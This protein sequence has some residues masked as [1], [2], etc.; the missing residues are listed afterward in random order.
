[1]FLLMCVFWSRARVRSERP[2]GGFW[3]WGTAVGAGPGSVKVTMGVFA[4]HPVEQ[5]QAPA[6][7]DQSLLARRTHGRAVNREV[8][9]VRCAS[10]CVKKAAGAGVCVAEVERV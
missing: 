7:G 6:L 1:M 9:S 2:S 8:C 4:E 3:G 5:T 10:G